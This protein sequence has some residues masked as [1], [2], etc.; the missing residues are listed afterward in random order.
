[1]L[2]RPKRKSRNAN[3]IAFEALRV[4]GNVEA[5]ST[6]TFQSDLRPVP[7]LASG[8]RVITSPTVQ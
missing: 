7:P 4:S 5:F 1:M 8:G 6:Y 3:H 2:F